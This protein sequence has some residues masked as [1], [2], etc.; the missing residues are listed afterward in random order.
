MGS[1]RARGQSVST[2]SPE[3]LFPPLKCGFDHINFGWHFPGVLFIRSG[4]FA[5]VH[6]CTKTT[7]FQG[8]QS[9]TQM[10]LRLQGSVQ[11]LCKA[12]RVKI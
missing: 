2:A 11:R 9:E 12:L 7:M 8:Q 4:L 6:E 1:S 5:E 3:A 10:I